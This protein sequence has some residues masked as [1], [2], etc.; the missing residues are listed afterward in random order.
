MSPQYEVVRQGCIFNNTAAGA[1]CEAPRLK[2]KC[3]KRDDVGVGWS[4][5]YRTTHSIGT[6]S[7]IPDA[8]PIVKYH[9]SACAYVRKNSLLHLNQ[10]F[11]SVSSV[12]S[13]I[14]KN[15]GYCFMPCF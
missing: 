12:S 6:A 13:I 2:A 10:R 7:C 5:A 3:Y 4:P 1:G 15:G 8:N 9:R 14:S 11:P